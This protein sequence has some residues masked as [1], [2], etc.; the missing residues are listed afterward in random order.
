MP[1]Y[2][3]RCPQCGQFYE[4][5]RPASRADDE[6]L[7]VVD[8]ARC[9]RIEEM[10]EEQIEASG[11]NNEAFAWYRSGHTH[12]DF[13][14]VHVERIGVALWSDMLAELRMQASPWMERLR[15]AGFRGGDVLSA[16]LSPAVALYSAYSIVED[17]HGEHVPLGGDAQATDPHV[18]GFLPYV[19]EILGRTA[20]DR[21]FGAAP[22]EAGRGSSDAVEDDAR[23]TA[24]FLLWQT[25]DR[26]AGD[27]RP[28][29]ATI[30]IDLVRTF[31][32][33]LGIH[34]EDEEGR[35]L[36]TADDEV[37]LL[38]I[39]ERSA[40]LLPAGTTIE[41]LLARDGTALDRLHTAMLLQ[42]AGRA[43]DL[44]AYL[45]A[46]RARPEFLRLATA[47]SR[48]YPRGSTE[49]RLLG[50]VLRVMPT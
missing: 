14:G 7:C 3:Y 50:E 33:P 13:T 37:R 8:Q 46:Q 28:L 39:H 17:E 49:H 6:L 20:L 9:F 19:W 47:L 44:R 31:S 24:L 34:V 26:A 1:L 35:I 38:P 22:E 10:T 45:E 21:A 36:A 4:V 16:C 11:V 18:R 32:L 5:T 43:E 2:D 29:D 40:A 41:A 23:L 48:L 30:G 25:P 42:D 27:D 15:A 12:D